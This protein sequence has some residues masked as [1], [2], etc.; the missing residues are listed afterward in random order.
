[1]PPLMD[2]KMIRWWRDEQITS[3]YGWREPDGFLLPTEPDPEE[4]DRVRDRLRAQILTLNR[5]LGEPDDA[6]IKTEPR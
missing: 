1:M 2:E 5:V 6:G 4:R 3:L